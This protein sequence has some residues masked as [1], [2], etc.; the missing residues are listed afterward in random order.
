MARKLMVVVDIVAKD[1]VGP[2]LYFQH[3]APAIRFFTDAIQDETTPLS[4]HPADYELR[5]IGILDDNLTVTLHQETIVTGEQ[6]LEQLKKL[7]AAQVIPIGQ[8]S[9]G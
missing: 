4:K 5:Q 9:N 2:V 1:V 3:N 8:V 7:A 6:V